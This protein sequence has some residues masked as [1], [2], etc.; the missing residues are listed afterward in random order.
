MGKTHSPEGEITMTPFSIQSFAAYCERAM[1][2]AP[3]RREAAERCLEQ[4]LQRYAGAEIIEAL[5]AAVP[6]GAS[7]GELVVFRSSELTMLYARVPP[8]FKSG[9]H[10]HTVFACMGQLEGAERSV[11]Y[12]RSESGAALEVAQTQTISAGQVM[13]LPED[14]I[15]HIENP[16]YAVSRSLHIYGGDFEAVREHRSLWSHDDH[17]QS[18]FSFPK[19]LQES[20][21]G[22]KL[23]RNQEGLDAIL[24]AI[25]DAR[26]WVE[27]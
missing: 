5:E 9:I 2:E 3:N 1:A 17:T 23:D 14:A 24:K 13:S 25:P 26:A 4:A 21:K 15:H 18:P 16:E 11:V 6:A 12:E 10:D 19:L 8:R 27:A 22:M 7:I 20:V